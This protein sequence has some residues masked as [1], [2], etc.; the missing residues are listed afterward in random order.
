MLEAV[1]LWVHCR[2]PSKELKNKMYTNGL[3]FLIYA[4]SVKPQISYIEHYPELIKKEAP[5][6]LHYVGTG[7]LTIC[8]AKCQ[9][10]ATKI[11][12]IR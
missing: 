1:A 6:C 9:L 3:F 7:Q 12:K 11:F 8:Y 4:N 10:R 5:L 2:H